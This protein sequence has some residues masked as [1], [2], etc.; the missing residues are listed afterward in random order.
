MYSLAISNMLFRGDGKS[1]IFNE[2]F[3]SN[4][5]DEILN[6]LPNKPTIGFINPPYGGKDNKSNPTKKEIQFLEKML[7]NCSRYGIIIAPLSTYFKDDNN[8]NRILSK[9]TLKY[10]INMP[11][12]LFQPNASTHTAIAVF[13]TNK[14]H[15][16]SKVVLYDL[17]DDGLIYLKQKV[18]LM[19]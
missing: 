16:N 13:E 10:V 18:E 4:K 11:S 5:T 9:H 14:P 1:Q 2:D 19:F 7:D 8:R 15:N 12:E 3:F 6:N 17:E